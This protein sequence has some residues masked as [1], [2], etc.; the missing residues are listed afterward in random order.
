M[1]TLLVKKLPIIIATLFTITLLVTGWF[2]HKNFYRTIVQAEQVATLRE[3]VALISFNESLWEIVREKL[4][5]KK[6]PVAIPANLND[7]FHL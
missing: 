5:N 2:L 4:N 6:K 3:Q 7:P 1:F